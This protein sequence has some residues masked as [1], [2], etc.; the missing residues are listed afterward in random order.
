MTNLEKLQNWYIQQID[1]DWE[2]TYGVKIDTLDNPAWLLEVDLAQ[3]KYQNLNIEYQ[4]FEKSKTDWYAIKI[5]NHKFKATGDP[6][7][8]DILI[9]KFFE[10]IEN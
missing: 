9:S 7:K 5:Q 6:T 1:G 4:I 8:L 3:T 10:V 2:H